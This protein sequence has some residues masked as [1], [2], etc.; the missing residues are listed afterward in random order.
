MSA[1]LTNP[2]MSIV[3]RS[4][5][6]L[7]C[8]IELIDRCLNQDYENFEIVVIDQSNMSHWQDHKETLSSIDQKIRLIRTKPRGSAAARNLGV[9][10]SRGDVVLLMDDDDLPVNN[11]WISSHAKN[12]KDPFCVGVSGRC[13][14]EVNE[15]NPYKNKQLAYERCLSYSFFLRGRD[16][17]GIDQVKKPVQ[18]LH[19][20]NSSIRRSYV[21]ELGGWYPFINNFDE[22]SFC[23][24]LQK[25][26]RPKEYLMFDPEPTVLRRFDIPGG[27]GKRHL[28]LTQL[29]RNQL[30]FYHRVVGKHFPLRFY[31]LYPLFSLYAFRYIIR[32]F[33]RFSYFNDSIWFKWFKKKNA[34][35]LYFLQEF[36]K[37][38]LL[39]L[40]FL[41]I[42]R[43][44]WTGP[45][46]ISKELFS[47]YKNGN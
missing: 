43:P 10:V 6:R 31:M 40:Q 28:P 7:D 42:K 17:T 16:F 37:Y 11:N 23:F 12:Y 39:V 4:Y 38:P 2:F 13:I 9:F 14:K 41:F 5:N 32:W 44:P 18:W 30:L 21:I 27:L 29:L 19:G 3:I 8:V 46:I 24:K 35:R 36:V 26:M 34:M 15:K 47:E 45:L 20:L 25:A 1:S 33:R 22:H